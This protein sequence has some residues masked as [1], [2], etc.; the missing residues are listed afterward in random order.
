MPCIVH[1]WLFNNTGW[2]F[3]GGESQVLV[4]FSSIVFQCNLQPV[5]HT[6]CNGMHCGSACLCSWQGCEKSVH[7]RT[8]AEWA[9][10]GVEG[11][12]GLLPPACGCRPFLPSAGVLLF[13][14][15]ASPALGGDELFTRS[16]APSLSGRR[17]SVT[18]CALAE[19]A[20]SA[21]PAHSL[22]RRCNRIAQQLCMSTCFC[23]DCGNAFLAVSP[24]A[25]CVHVRPRLSIMCV[26]HC[27]RV[28]MRIQ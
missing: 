26:H 24:S 14:G 1:Q 3:D 12:L 27:H 21:A 13:V 6:A 20:S 18:L 25:R 8:A 15:P 22:A 2:A 9:A 4:S 23:V 28:C 11:A 7:R 19:R 17:G 16:P 5:L 10:P